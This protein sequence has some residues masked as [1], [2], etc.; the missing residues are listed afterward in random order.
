MSEEDAKLIPPKKPRKKSQA[1]EAQP[2]ATVK[3]KSAQLLEIKGGKLQTPPVPS[4]GSVEEKLVESALL[5]NPKPKTQKS[6][7]DTPQTLVAPPTARVEEKPV[8]PGAE[9]QALQAPSVEKPVESGDEP[10]LGEPNPTATTEENQASSEGDAEASA[11]EE[12]DSGL[13]FQAIGVITG[14]VKFSEDNKMSVVIGTNEYRLF[15]LPKKRRS[16]EAL[17]KEIEATGEYTQRLVVYP[18]VMHFPSKDQ[19]HAIT[20]QLV[21]FDNERKETGVSKELGNMEYEPPHRMADGVSN[22]QSGFS[23]SY[24]RATCRTFT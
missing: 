22:L 5:E 11:L 12:E 7:S 3:E 16:L 14:K 24:S 15:Y 20:F 8:E 10:Q 9:L 19:P 13:M 1:T 2:T 6:K 4:T 18:R 17:K 21:G 23:R